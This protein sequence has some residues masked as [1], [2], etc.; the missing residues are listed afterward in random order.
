MSTHRIGEILY[1]TDL[2]EAADHALDHVGLLARRFLARV[3]L[4]HAVARPDPAQPH[5]AFDHGEGVWSRIEREARDA[6]LERARRLEVPHEVIVERAPDARRA[7]LLQIQA[8][9]PDLT[10]LGRHPRSRGGRALVGSATDEMLKHPA[11]P[12]L[13]VRHEHEARPYR[14]I[15]VPTDLDLPSKLSFPVVACI[16][17]AFEAE[18]LLVHVAGGLSSPPREVPTESSLLRAARRD[19]AGVEVAA[20]VVDG[21]VSSAILETARLEQSDLIAMA[22]RGRHNVPD[23][24]LG[25]QTERVLRTAP[26]PLLV[27]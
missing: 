3:V 22:T 1:P 5:W 11:H 26:C 17:R 10:V 9:R 18:V 19:M 23:L 7:L 6:L 25:S 16:A 27:A 14:R 20:R 12:L 24:I 4:Y 15:L 2:S 13:C 21:T 8:R